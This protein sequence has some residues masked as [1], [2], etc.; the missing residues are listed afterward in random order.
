MVS[1]GSGFG[2]RGSEGTT[3]GWGLGTL[4]GLGFLVVTTSGAAQEPSKQLQ[5]AEEKLT[6]RIYDYAGTPHRTLQAASG[7]AAT[8]LAKAGVETEWQLC[9]AA[10]GQT[11]EACNESMRPDELTVRIVRRPRPRNG[12]LGSTECGAAIENAQ[13]LGVYSTLYADCLD[14]MPRVDGLLPSAML[15]HLIAHEIGH[16]LLP[17]TDHAASG[18]MCPQ[19]REEDWNLARVEALTFT[20]RQAAILRAEVESRA[21]VQTAL[22]KTP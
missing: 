12:A 16:L 9:A 10:E 11:S 3:R 4:I 7:E 17:G 21:K 8:I 13:G 22:A 6:V 2:A 14:T 20:P 15:G 18:I 1:R 19:M 5:A